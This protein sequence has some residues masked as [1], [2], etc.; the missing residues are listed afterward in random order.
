VAMQIQDLVSLYETKTDEELFHLAADL[1]QLTTE[2]RLALS[3]ELAKRRIDLAKCRNSP[4]ESNPSLIAQ[5]A[6]PTTVPTT[7][8]AGVADFVAQVLRVYHV[9]F[10]LFVKLTVPAVVAGYF[11]VTLCRQEGHEIARHLPR[12][13]DVL[14]HRIE[15]LEIWF[16]NLAGWLGSWMAFSTSF[17]AICSV[18][19]RIESGDPPSV[20]DALADLR[21]NLGPFVRLM[22]LLF[23]LCLLAFGIPMSLF[24][25]I[26]LLEFWRRLH[27]GGLTFS[28]LSVGFTGIGLLVLTR[29]ALAVPAVVLDGYR[30][31]SA[32]FRSDELT[33]G[34]WP[35]LAALV[36]KSLIGGYLAAVAPFWLASWILRD[37]P[38]PYGFPWILT[39]VSMG[40]VTVVEPTMFIGFALLYLRTSAMPS[41]PSE[42]LTQLA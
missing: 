3:N 2:A 9:H 40:A 12:G 41:P 20:S 15:I 1:S 17:A 36:S 10:W 18:V 29:F 19:R 7:K 4:D 5:A 30:I 24:T 39:V 35:I 8:S 14:E 22:F 32:M 26:L 42:P 31:R 11:A 13:I 25:G 34:K 33:E 21:H 27:L 6:T 16:V 37:T 38:L 23:G 28:L